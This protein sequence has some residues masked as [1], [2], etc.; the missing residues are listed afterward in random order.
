M[1]TASARV[2]HG[3]EDNLGRVYIVTLDL[4]RCGW[5]SGNHRGE[6]SALGPCYYPRC[7]QARRACG[8][9]S[10]E[11]EQVGPRGP[12]ARSHDFGLRHEAVLQ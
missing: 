7:E 6:C 10:L 11:T 9:W 3:N 1:R 4:Q 8:D 2:A 5:G 12:P